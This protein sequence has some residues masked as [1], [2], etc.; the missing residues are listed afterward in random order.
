MVFA[1]VK[2]FIYFVALDP[3]IYIGELRGV[4]A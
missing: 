1:P 2:R 4:I 3:E